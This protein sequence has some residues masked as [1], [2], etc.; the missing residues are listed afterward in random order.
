MER[1]SLP[2]WPSIELRLLL[3]TD[4]SWARR[5]RRVFGLYGLDVLATCESTVDLSLE[6]IG[7]LEPDLIVV[8]IRNPSIHLAAVMAYVDARPET[9]LLIHVARGLWRQRAMT[10]RNAPLPLSERECLA[11]VVTL[12]RFFQ[13]AR[14]Q[15]AP[16]VDFA[17]LGAWLSMAALDSTVAFMGTRIPSGCA[18]GTDLRP[19][20]K[21]LGQIVRSPRCLGAYSMEIPSNESALSALSRIDDAIGD[22]VLAFG[23]VFSRSRFMAH[24]SRLSIGILERGDTERNACRKT[25]ATCEQIREGSYR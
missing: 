9:L 22:L 3:A 10:P 21:R 7:R 8:S 14:Y 2:V 11:D 15:G 16:S 18:R 12:T 4:S 17:D 23:T 19:S 13:A 20:L 1:E 5:F 24:Q 25:A 6:A